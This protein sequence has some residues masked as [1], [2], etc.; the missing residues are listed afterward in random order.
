MF[1]NNL[2]LQSSIESKSEAKEFINT[3]DQQENE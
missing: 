2:N 3:S 1:E